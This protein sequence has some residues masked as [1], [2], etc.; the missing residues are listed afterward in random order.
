M[1][2]ALLIIATGERYRNYAVSHAISADIYFIPHDTVIFT[3]NEEIFS[4]EYLSIFKNWQAKYFTIPCAYSGYPESTLRRYNAFAANQHFLSSYE[5][6]FYADADMRWVDKVSEDEIL[7]SGITATEHPGYVGTHGTPETRVE[8]TAYCLQPRTY[9]CGGF[10]GGTSEA[11]LAMS[12]TLAR[13]IDDDARCGITAVWYDESHLN[14]YLYDNPPA[15]ILTPSFCYPEKDNYY[16]QIWQN[17]K[18]EEF[19]PKL[20]ALDKASHELA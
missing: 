4:A 11:F 16:K 14:R 1:R 19:K 9:F 15:K 20:I 7:S 13:N 17:A 6:L 2:T 18:R 5:Y 10:Q 3:D 12:E 8:S